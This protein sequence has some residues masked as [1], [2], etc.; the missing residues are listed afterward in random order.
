MKLSEYNRLRYAEANEER[1]R[2]PWVAILGVE[3]DDC[4]GQVEKNTSEVLLTIPT[5]YRTRC[6]RCDRRGYTVAR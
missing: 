5:Q 4:G 6:Q 1:N 3:C 2:S